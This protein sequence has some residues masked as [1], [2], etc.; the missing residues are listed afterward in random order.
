MAFAGFIT[1]IR[2]L[3]A[4]LAAA[5]FGVDQYFLY[6]YRNYDQVVFHWRFYSQVSISGIVFLFVIISEVVYRISRYNDRD[7]YY[8]QYGNSGKSKRSCAHHFWSIFRFIWAMIFAAG[9]LAWVVPAWMDNQRIMF[10]IPVGRNSP[11]ADAYRIGRKGKDWV[12]PVNIFD[13]PTWKDGEPLTYLCKLDE[14]VLYA[15]AALACLLAIEGFFTIIIDSRRRNVVPYDQQPYI[16]PATGPQT[17]TTATAGHVVPMET[18]NTTQHVPA[19]AAD[20]SPKQK[21]IFRSLKEHI[22]RDEV[23]DVE[24]NYGSSG[25]NPRTT[26]VT[27]AH[28]VGYDANRS[29]PALP[30]RPTTTNEEEDEEVRSDS[31]MIPKSVPAPPIGGAPGPNPF[32]T[33]DQVRQQQLAYSQGS[34]SSQSPYAADIKSADGA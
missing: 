23:Y 25:Y 13:C 18:L 1:F 24:S 30:A 10:T 9:I 5:V 33:D 15:S 34:G 32:L 22:R 7:E 6:L 19:P 28:H 29:L 20:E 17:Y 16:V 2:V 3:V 14:Q 12:N 11:E 4:L 21:S 31:A 27:E 26:Y 8:H